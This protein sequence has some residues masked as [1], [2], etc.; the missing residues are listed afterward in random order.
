MS[1]DWIHVVLFTELFPTMGFEAVPVS[2]M[3]WGEESISITSFFS[4]IFSFLP[5]FIRN[6]TSPVVMALLVVSAVVLL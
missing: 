3:G 2:V 1:T 5:Q 6:P 4:Y